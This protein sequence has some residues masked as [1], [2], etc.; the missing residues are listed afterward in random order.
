M[1]E[2]V[3]T[4]TEKIGLWI[5]IVSCRALFYSTHY[6]VFFLLKTLPTEERT[7]DCEVWKRF[8]SGGMMV[9]LTAILVV[10]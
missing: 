7:Q 5:A 6:V 3:W 10:N 9:V 1:N 8:D 2:S 4:Q